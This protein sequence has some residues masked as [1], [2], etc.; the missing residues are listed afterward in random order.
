MG[1]VQTVLAF[2]PQQGLTNDAAVTQIAVST[3]TGEHEHHDCRVHLGNERP[4]FGRVQEGDVLCA[5]DL[6][7]AGSGYL[8]NVSSTA[9]TPSS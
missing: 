8:T 5:H 6:R 2:D 4:D 7:E 9:A 1:M 3:T